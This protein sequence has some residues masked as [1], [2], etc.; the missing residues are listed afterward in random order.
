[1]SDDAA[2]ARRG[3]GMVADGLTAGRALL[4]VPLAVVAWSG[5]WTGAC[6]LLA[7]SWWSDLLDGRLARRFGGATRLGRWDLAADTAVG[8][9]L[10]VGL[11]G[12]GH[13]PAP[14]WG[15]AGALFAA[16]YVG[17]R[18]PA[19]GM[20]LQA[21]AYGPTLWFGAVERSPGFGVA[22]LTIV[23]IAVVDRARLVGYV[24]PAFFGGLVGRRQGE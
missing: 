19:P 1:M 12:G 5:A 9:G 15:G 18:N 4:S 11:V 14:W 6:L 23:A 10:L 16:G 22:V 24:L 3:V 8:A 13:V 21:I 17:L 2:V 7:A 20:L